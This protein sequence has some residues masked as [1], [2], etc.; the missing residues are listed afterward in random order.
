MIAIVNPWTDDSIEMPRS[1]W[2]DGHSASQCAEKIRKH[3]QV[4]LS[5]NAVI[6][7]IHRM[8]LKLHGNPAQAPKDKSPQAR[9]VTRSTRSRIVRSRR[10]EA[11]LEPD[12]VVENPSESCPGVTIMNVGA[13]QCRWP[14]GER[15]HD[16]PMCGTKV[17]DVGC[18]YCR[19]HARI[20]FNPVPQRR[21]VA[22]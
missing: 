3:F 5:R 21:F 12:P 11:M 8:G 10:N 13:D 15:A 22:E 2:T 6:G 19:R 9:P 1:L 14:L 17:A 4:S 18:S 7:K 20:A 16:M